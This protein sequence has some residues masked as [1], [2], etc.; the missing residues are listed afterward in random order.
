MIRKY[1]RHQALKFTQTKEIKYKSSVSIVNFQQVN[2]GWL[3]SAT[4]AAVTEELSV[5]LSVTL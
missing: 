4:A 3:S 2:A 5:I 1:I